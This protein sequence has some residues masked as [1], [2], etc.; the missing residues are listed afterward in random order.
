MITLFGATGYT[1]T[2]TAHSLAR[3]G[4]R[5][6][7]A[8]RNG[9][10]LAA[11]ADE[12][13]ERYGGDFEFAEADVANPASIRALLTGPQDVL[14]T[15]VGPFAQWGE[16]AVEAAIDAGATYIDSTGE[17]PFIRAIFE[18]WG[19][20]ARSAGSA[21]LTAFGYDYV[22]GNLAGAVAIERGLAA[23]HQ[24]ARVD[25]G[26]FTPS[27]PGSSAG[28]SGGT[29]ASA[30]GIML[31]PSYAWH[32]GRL[33]TERPA[34][35]VRDFEVTD[36][37]TGGSA[38]LSALTVGGTEPFGLP[39]LCPTLTDVDVY[40]GW[41]GKRSAMVSHAS[42]LTD[43]AAKVPGVG[44]VLRAAARRGAG[45]GSS[46]GPDAQARAGVHSMA[47]AETF[48]RN[49]ARFDQVVVDGPSPYDLTADLLAWAAVEAAAG[50][51]TRSGALAPTD[52]F[53]VDGLIAGCA[54]LGMIARA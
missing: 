30:A 9:D 27:D 13:A 1:G 10:K 53:G 38:Q 15:T 32:G 49:G 11:L 26:Y 17:P 6:L 16:P 47:V 39:N 51:I 12:L 8:G 52:A 14:V 20:R 31:E 42:A 29:K 54:Q 37:D 19:P 24:I 46:G 3:M 50:A 5:P 21:L 40:L 48:D 2:L 25:I 4:A 23:G 44:S 28:I 34:K 36:P 41:A 7:L 18:Q 33:V 45:S 43:L 22:P 35:R